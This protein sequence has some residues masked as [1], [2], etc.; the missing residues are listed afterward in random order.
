MIRQPTVSIKDTKSM[1]SLHGSW[2]D[3]LMRMETVS[4]ASSMKA[5]DEYGIF[6]PTEMRNEPFLLVNLPINFPHLFWNNVVLFSPLTLSL[7]IY[8]LRLVR[9]IY[10]CFH[11]R[12]FFTRLACDLLVLIVHRRLWYPITHIAALGLTFIFVLDFHFLTPE[13]CSQSFSL[14]RW[15]LWMSAR[16]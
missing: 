11:L 8:S 12:N 7:H 6:S 15:S 13:S 3:P 10:S 9:I 1:M 5:D 4:L 2:Y 16:L 14:A